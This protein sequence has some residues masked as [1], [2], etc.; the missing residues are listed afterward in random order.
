MGFFHVL[1]CRHEDKIQATVVYRCVNNCSS[2]KNGTREREAIDEK[3]HLYSSV[4][5]YLAT[6]WQQRKD[7]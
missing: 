6:S 7:K 2:S 5:N 4:G 1:M 3:G